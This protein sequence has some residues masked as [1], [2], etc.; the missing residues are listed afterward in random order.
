MYF[1]GLAEV[2]MDL[3]NK[4]SIKLLFQD[5]NF[6]YFSYMLFFSDNI[7]KFYLIY[8]CHGFH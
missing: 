6:K 7:V 2:E 4:I 8:I 5:S 1:V 3:G